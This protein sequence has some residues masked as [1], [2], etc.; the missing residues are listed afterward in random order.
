MTFF[1]FFTYLN[2]LVGHIMGYGVFLFKNFFN[3]SFII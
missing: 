3:P 2:I 1:L